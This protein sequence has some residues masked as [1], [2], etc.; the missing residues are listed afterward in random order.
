MDRFRAGG[1]V[2][3]LLLVGLC[4][5]VLAPRCGLDANAEGDIISLVKKTERAGL[6][7]PIPGAAAPLVS[8]VHHY[9]RLTVQVD[10][11]AGTAVAIATLDFTGRLGPTEVSSLGLE[12]IPFRYVDGEWR[13]EKGL[14]PLLT[15]SLERLE[16]RRRALEKGDEGRLARLFGGEPEALARDAALRRVLQMTSRSYRVKAWYLRS[17]RE[18]IQI[19]EAYR[20]QAETPDRP[21]DEEGLRSLGLTRRGQELFFWPSLM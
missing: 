10:H 9:D 12:R 17:E 1:V 15:A 2:V 13:P 8:Q 20:L 6:S 18:G 19:S 4:V 21:V 14:A 7:L 5:A 3:S 11:A 16:A